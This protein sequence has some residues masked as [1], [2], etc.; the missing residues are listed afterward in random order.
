MSR[1]LRI[2]L[3]ASATA[4]VVTI[5]LAAALFP[6]IGSWYVRTR[7]LPGVSE[8]LGRDLT[9]GNIRVGY[10]D[11]ELGDVR[12]YGAKDGDGAILTVDDIRVDFD[13]WRA[14][15][16]DLHL[17]TL[18][19]DRPR[20]TVTRF[21]DGSD[22]FSDLLGKLRGQ[23]SHDGAAGGGPRYLPERIL[24][25]HASAAYDDRLNG[26]QAAIDDAQGTVVSHGPADI[27]LAGVTAVHS[28][29]PRFAAASLRIS[30]DTTDIRRTLALTIAGGS[31]AL[32]PK[33]SLTDIQGSI[34]AAG[35]PGRT[36]LALEGGYGGAGEKLWRA[37]GWVDPF[38]G[39]AE[40]HLRADRFTLDKIEKILAD[41]PVQDPAR[42]SV[43][44]ALDLT[45]HGWDVDFSGAFGLSGLTLY[46]PWLS[47]ELVRELGGRA[48]IRGKILRK[49]RVL[50]VDELTVQARGVELHV[51]GAAA[52]ERG[53][54]PDGTR[55][56]ERRVRAHIVIPA[57][58]CQQA[59]AAIPAELT[60][61][62]Q[63]FQL[64]G[65]F[66][67]DLWIGV[68]WANL[69]A[70]ELNGNV[71]IFGCKVLK[72][73]EGFRPEDLQGEFEHMVELEENNFMSF[74]VGPSNPDFVPLPEVSHYLVDSLISTEDSGFLKHKGFI[75]REFK[76]ALI[77]DLKE[78]YFKYGA[79][80]ITMQIA[81]NVFLYREKTLSR[82]LQELFLTW[83]LEQVL[84]KERLLE[85]YVNVIEFGPG[86]Y[87]IGPA[88]QAYFG[89]RARDLNPLEAAFF[90]SILPSPKKRYLQY[91][92]GELNR[93]GDAKVQRILKLNHERGLITDAEYEAAQ[94]TPLQFARTETFSKEECVTMTKRMIQKTRPTQPPGIK[95]SSGGR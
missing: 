44:A 22:N 86:I 79:S 31:A 10:G 41:T 34:T 25:R 4:L 17:G 75:V 84:P 12:V 85:I 50:E 30:A 49:E 5:G 8:R 6:K 54:E 2:V 63:G 66:S 27:V 77:K 71:G 83:Y 69:D 35:E 87:G 62:L 11:V 70:L 82:K 94:A 40:F 46:H 72:A 32:W 65:N 67:T 53:I 43:D 68:D 7:V 58:P 78:G 20:V 61:R 51:A 80:S 23:P 15:R 57:V 56:A 76:S 28:V 26:V 16:G 90:S 52:L 47:A 24:V 37:D 39:D 91:C 38:A 59:L 64:K 81:K 89:K 88:A 74:V 36:R 45:A 29:G 21:G 9:V 19:I 95:T 42:T 18:V 73:P 3:I 14:V 1:R 60:P 13:F 33:M 48:T 92:E 93:W 55:R